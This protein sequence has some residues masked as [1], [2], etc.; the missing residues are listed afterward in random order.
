MADG[1]ASREEQ[2]KAAAN[3]ALEL[4][5]TVRAQAQKAVEI[6]ESVDDIAGVEELLSLAGL[7]QAATERAHEA[8]KQIS[9][10][11]EWSLRHLAAPD[12][13]LIVSI[14]IK[15]KLLTFSVSG[16]PGGINYGS[17]PLANENYGR[18]AGID[19]AEQL[20]AFN[21]AVLDAAIG[22]E[23]ALDGLDSP[24]FWAAFEPAA[25]KLDLHSVLRKHVA[26]MP[27]P[28]N[29]AERPWH[30]WTS[31]AGL[32]ARLYL[33]PP[34]PIPIERTRMAYKPAIGQVMKVVLGSV[35]R[36]SLEFSVEN[37]ED[38]AWIHEALNRPSPSSWLR[39]VVLQLAGR[40][41]RL[42]HAE[43]AAVLAGAAELVDPRLLEHCPLPQLDSLLRS[44]C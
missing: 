1:G 33:Q 29:N 30:C 40:P 34:Q 4:L 5:E 37:E 15:N 20:A 6:A 10:Q 31:H 39:C 8:A 35:E 25:N 26:R 19:N 43:V 44:I 21:E 9:N 18:P 36:G 38:R 13:K 32:L 28:P 12:S 11:A 16:R 41:H 17:G 27:A 14:T 7:L 24:E 22:H 23:L 3:R 42:V 2:G